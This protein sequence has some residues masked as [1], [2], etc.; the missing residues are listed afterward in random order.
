[1][2]HELP[3]LPYAPDA[4]E[5]HI[6]R[7]TMEFHHGEHR[8][9]RVEK[10]NSL[11]KGTQFEG[12]PLEEIVRRADDGIYNNAAQHCSSNA[13]TARSRSSPCRTPIRRFVSGRAPC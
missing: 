12:M 7:E 6:S 4:L 3:P 8:K 1:M 10:L 9:T 13:K 2:A 5:P 11:I